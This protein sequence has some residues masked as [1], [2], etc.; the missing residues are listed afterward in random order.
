MNLKYNQISAIEIC[1]N[2]NFESG[3]ISH[4]TGT[5]KSVTRINLINEYINLF[6]I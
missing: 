6:G 4:A 5:G 2:N 3:T 1:K